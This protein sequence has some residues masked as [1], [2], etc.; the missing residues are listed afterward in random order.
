MTLFSAGLQIVHPRA[1][2]GRAERPLRFSRL[3][4]RTCCKHF[5]ARVEAALEIARY[6]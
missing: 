4:R 3:L 2:R 1:V 6:L 5:C